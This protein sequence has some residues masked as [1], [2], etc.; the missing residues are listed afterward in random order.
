MEKTAIIFTTFLRDELA[1]KTIHSIA[2]YIKPE[3]VLLIG[4]QNPSEYKKHEYSD[5]LYYPLPKDCGL[6]FARN[7]LIQRAHLME[8]PYILMTADSIEF[9]QDYNLE[10]LIAFLDSE[11]K[12]GKIG[13]NLNNRIPWE[14]NMNL[15]DSFELTISKEFK[16]FDKIKFHKVDIC[17]NFFL[18]KTKAFVTIPYDNQL[19][20]MEHEDHCW[21][22]K[23][24]GWE[25][26]YTDA[27]V[28]NYIKF[29]NPS[30]DKYRQRMSKEF[31]PILLKKYGI[32]QWVSYSPE[33]T[34][35]FDDWR[36][37]QKKG[38]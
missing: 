19:K 17:R 24:G 13:F 12:I 26:Y 14:F 16:E 30:Y 6:S 23:Q 36:G 32:K 25:T 9:T 1:K 11:E 4:D 21:R 28:A 34:K 20:L 18:G 3:Y 22:F 15:K 33:V 7:Y 37:Q 10:P 29:S 5:F 27:V 8:I 2:R 31:R 38:I 35:L